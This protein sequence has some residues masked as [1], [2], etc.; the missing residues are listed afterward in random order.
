[1]IY[2]KYNE[3]NICE[4]SKFGKFREPLKKIFSQIHNDKERQLVFSYVSKRNQ[5]YGVQVYK[6]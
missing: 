2:N 3:E 5:A 4:Q 1:M 6:K